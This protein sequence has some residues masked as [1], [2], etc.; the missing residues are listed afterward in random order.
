MKVFNI[1][2]PYSPTLISAET[3]GKYIDVIP[4][5]GILICNDEEGIILYDIHDPSR[6][7]LIKKVS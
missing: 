1:K 4:Y 3:D 2:D 6:P 5:N 7:A